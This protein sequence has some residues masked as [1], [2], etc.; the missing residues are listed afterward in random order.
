MWL[1]PWQGALGLP[2]PKVACLEARGRPEREGV[3]HLP[4]AGFARDS[5]EMP[6]L[7]LCPWLHPSPTPQAGHPGCTGVCPAAPS[8]QQA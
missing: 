7:P 3:P 2:A 5:E 6:W 4:L 8:M 1:T